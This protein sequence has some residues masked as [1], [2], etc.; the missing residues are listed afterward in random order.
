MRYTIKVE[1][2]KGT[3]FKAVQPVYTKKV[4]D[5]VVYDRHGIHF[6]FLQTGRLGKFDFQTLLLS[7]VSGIGLITVS[8]VVVDF[9][10]TK[11]L[12][13]K[14]VVTELKYHETG[15]LLSLEEKDL[16]VLAQRLRQIN[17]Q[18]LPLNEAPGARGDL[19]S[20][21][22]GVASTSSSST[23]ETGLRQPLLQQQQA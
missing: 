23:E 14:D 20:P 19:P 21:P 3:K 1:A 6:I 17:S 22:S 13:A 5:R 4:E 16:L 18:L 9:I 12:K 10:A 2:S 15:N 8:T 11:I 7:F